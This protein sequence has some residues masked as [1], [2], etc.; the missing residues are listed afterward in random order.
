MDFPFWANEQYKN[1]FF[2]IQ[3]NFITIHLSCNIVKV[4]GCFDL[5]GII[6]GLQINGD[7]NGIELGST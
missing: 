4:F 6:I 5:S 1:N 2:T 7:M 3:C